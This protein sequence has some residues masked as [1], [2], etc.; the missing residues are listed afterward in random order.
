MQITLNGQPHELAATRSVEQLLQD[1]GLG[2]KPVVVELNLEA[3][4]PRDFSTT[5]VNDGDRVEIVT[6]AAGG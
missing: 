4:F 1:V 3:I 2:G 5:Q 6:L